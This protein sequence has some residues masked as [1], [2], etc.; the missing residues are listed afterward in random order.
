MLNTQVIKDNSSS[1]MLFLLL[2]W[3]GFTGNAGPIGR[4][5][6]PGSSGISGIPGLKGDVGPVGSNGFT[7][8]F[9]ILN[10]NFFWDLCQ[11]I[12]KISLSCLEIDFLVNVI[13]QQTCGHNISLLNF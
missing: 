3:P 6:L 4:T 9:T 8:E 12:M 11:C 7:G 2:H 13:L 10:K 5:G 1:L